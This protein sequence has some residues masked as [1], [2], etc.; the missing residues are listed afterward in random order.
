VI[1]LDAVALRGLLD[2]AL[3]PIPRYNAQIVAARL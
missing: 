1:D 3:E 2:D